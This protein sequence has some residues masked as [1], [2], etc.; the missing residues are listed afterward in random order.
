[1]NLG[2]KQYGNWML[3]IRNDYPK[4]MINSSDVSVV[5]HIIEVNLKRMKRKVS[6]LQKNILG[7]K[8]CIVQLL[9]QL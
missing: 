8:L 4:M 7:K 3:V 6:I 9:A 2:T 1:M 5:K